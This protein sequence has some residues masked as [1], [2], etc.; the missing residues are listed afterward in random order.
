[1][2]T[3]RA[4]L[5]DFDG[6]IVESSPKHTQA[7]LRA[8]FDLAPDIVVDPDE[9]KAYIG[10]DYLDSI[11]AMLA[12]RGIDNHELAIAITERA[13]EHYRT[14]H[15]TVSTVP[16]VETFMR[17]AHAAGLELAIVSGSPRRILEETMHT[18]NM[19]QLISAFI[20]RDD[21]SALKPHPQPYMSALDA[22]GVLPEEALAFEDSPTGVES[23]WLASIPTIGITTSFDIEDLHKTIF[24][25]RDYRDF[26]LER[27]QSLHR[28]AHA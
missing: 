3:L 13:V 17:A 15:N 23:A 22:L 12:Q 18:L 16:G 28:D 20:G 25:I 14:L 2:S 1:M 19:H 26:S 24:T 8:F 27:A 4:L 7:I 11:T 9:R 5:L 21:V 10:L 6:T